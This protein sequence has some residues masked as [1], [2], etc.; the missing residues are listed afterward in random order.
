[1][2]QIFVIAFLAV[3]TVASESVDIN[4]SRVRTLAEYPEFWK[5]NGL[6]PPVKFERIGQLVSNGNIAGRHD[7]P[8]KAALITSYS[9]GDALCGGS[10]ISR[11]SVLTAAHCVHGATDTTV[12]LGA[13]DIRDA[14]EPFQVRLRIPSDNFRFHPLFRPGVT[15]SDIAIV[16]F[17]NPIA[18]FTQ[19]VRPI[20]IPTDA[21][22]SDLFPS[23]SALVMGFGQYSQTGVNSPNLRFIEINTMPNG[24]LTGCALRFPGLIDHSHICTSG[25]A[26]RGTCPGDEGAPLIINRGG[27]YF[28]IGIASIFPE[29]GCLTGNP[30]VYTRVTSFMSFIRQNMD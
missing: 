13:S 15:N 21:M 5:K 4:W 9:F 16:R 2:K 27:T 30:S 8:F 10:L 3:A 26:G 25:L 17:N 12:V 19:A 11:W 14:A 24:G 20:D 7:F 28:Q 6:K 22:L 18:F 1:M 29:S 23:V